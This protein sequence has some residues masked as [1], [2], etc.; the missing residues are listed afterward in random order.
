MVMSAT[1]FTD[2]L[3]SPLDR[4]RTALFVRA[5]RVP[6]LRPVLLEK[7]RRVPALLLLHASA[8]LVLSVLSPTLLLIAGPLLLGVPHLLADLRYLVLRPALS[9]ALRRLLLG[10]CAALFLA[11]L[12]EV[13]R[14]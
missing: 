6:L 1:T 2:S 3:L 14:A 4:A 13:C 12:F 7:R 10:G 5:T 11:R 9:R 8:A